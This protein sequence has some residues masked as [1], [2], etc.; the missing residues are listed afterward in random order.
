MEKMGMP[1]AQGR[2]YL[3]GLKYL[4]FLIFENLRYMEFLKTYIFQNILSLPFYT[5]VLELKRSSFTIVH[6][7]F[8]LEFN[9]DFPCPSLS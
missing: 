5:Q 3:N 7:R 6:M 9:G 4:I 8:I 2:V 1:T